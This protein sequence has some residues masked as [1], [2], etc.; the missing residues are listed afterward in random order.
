MDLEATQGVKMLFLI[1]RKPTTSREELVMHWFKNHMPAVIK[2]QQDAKAAGRP[3]AWRYIATLFDAD[4]EGQHPWDGM[5]QLWWD[6]PLRRPDVPH[7]STPADTFQEKALPYLPWA[8]TEYVVIDGS[9]HLSAKPLTLNEPYP[10]S[11]SGFLRI[12]F[13]VRAKPGTDYETFFAHWLNVH[14]PNVKNTMDWAGGFRYVVSH[15][16]EPTEVPY[17]GLAE[18]YFHDPSGWD[19]YRELIKPDGMEEW[20]DPAGMQVLRGTTEMIGIP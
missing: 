5:A 1:K 12:S 4:R 14:V 13:L 20:V 15:S 3:H 2:G 9:E 7:G 18:L 17:A 6:K 16:M 11:R 19:R 8:T 10:S